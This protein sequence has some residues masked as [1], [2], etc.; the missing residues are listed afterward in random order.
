MGILFAGFKRCHTRERVA[1]LITRTEGGGNFISL[2]V[3][4][5]QET[6]PLAI[7]GE[8]IVHR[9][10]K[11]KEGK[12]ANSAPELSQRTGFFMPA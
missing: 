7:G 10:R 5:G 4:V 1:F 11:G 9:V 8:F 3:E 2:R 6:Y 12:S